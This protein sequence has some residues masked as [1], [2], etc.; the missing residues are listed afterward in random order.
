MSLSVTNENQSTNNV[1]RVSSKGHSTRYV[2]LQTFHGPAYACVVFKWEKSEHRINYTAG[3]SFC[4]PK[5]VFLKKRAREVAAARLE[6]ERGKAITSYVSFVER[7]VKFISNNEFEILFRDLVT[8]AHKRM[9]PTKKHATPNWG[10][11]NWAMKAMLEHKY[12]LGLSD[13]EPEV[14]D[15]STETLTDVSSNAIEEVVSSPVEEVSDE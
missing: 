12:A 4:S 2:R 10:A 3:V 13:K 5:D 9:L 1:P 8:Q 7:G 11:P 6:Q 15:L 14:V